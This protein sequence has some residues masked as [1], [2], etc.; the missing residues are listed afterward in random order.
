MK[1]TH[2]LAAFL[3][4]LLLITSGC[5]TSDKVSSITISASG[6]TGT[7]EVKGAGGTLQLAVTANYTS[8]KIVDV[9]NFSTYATTPTGTDDRGAP[10]PP[11][12]QTLSINATGMATAVPPFVCTFVD[13]T[14]NATASWALSGSYQVI[15]TYKGMSSQPA[16]IGVASATGVTDPT[17][18]CGP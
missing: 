7:F 11:S 12:P 1:R 16:F 6:A 5:G 9:T 13:T 2:I 14:P 15:A 10:L 18:A 8:G 4:A 3:G 17:G